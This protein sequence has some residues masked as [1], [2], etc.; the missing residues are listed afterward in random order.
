[1]SELGFSVA[2]IDGL[3]AGGVIGDFQLAAGSST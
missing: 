1:M 2:E 3:I